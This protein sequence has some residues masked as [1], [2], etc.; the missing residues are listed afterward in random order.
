[1]ACQ[2]RHWSFTLFQPLLFSLLW[3]PLIP[4]ICPFFL[5]YYVECWALFVS[6]CSFTFFC[7]LLL[8]LSLVNDFFGRAC[9][10]HFSRSLS[11]SLFFCLLYSSLLLFS[12]RGGLSAGWR[13]RAFAFIHGGGLPCIFRPLAARSRVRG[14]RK[15][16]PSNSSLPFSLIFLLFSCFDFVAARVH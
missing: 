9:V 2:N 6:N 11:P 12:F 13:L 7:P 8:S 15:R 5:S 1:M 3:L 14:G 10:V 16:S 4:L